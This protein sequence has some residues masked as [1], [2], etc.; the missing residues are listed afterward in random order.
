M[1][2]LLEKVNP[3]TFLL[4]FSRNLN[5]GL[6]ASH[7]TS[8]NNTKEIFLL[9]VSSTLGRL[10]ETGAAGLVFFNLFFFSL[11]LVVVVKDGHQDGGIGLASF[12][13]S[14]CGQE[15]LAKLRC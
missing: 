9:V 6:N 11:L 7:Q 2:G 8:M 14:C 3:S 10:T 1:F 12:K 15:L 4:C 13:S 5:D